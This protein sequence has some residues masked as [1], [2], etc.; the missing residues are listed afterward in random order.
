MIEYLRDQR[1]EFGNQTELLV[2]TV[3]DKAYAV[4][5]STLV[6]DA[7]SGS[8]EVTLYFAVGSAAIRITAVTQ[9]GDPIQDA[10]AVAE[11]IVAKS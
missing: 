7:P 4:E 5:G 9:G 3:G 10:I 8:T 2:D 11:A 1:I 6:S